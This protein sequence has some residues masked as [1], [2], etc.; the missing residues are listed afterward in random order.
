MKPILRR[1]LLACLASLFLLAGFSAWLLGTQSG[2]QH[3]LGWLQTWSGGKLQFA[4]ANGRWLGPLRLDEIVWQEADAAYRARDL[5]LDWQPAALFTLGRRAVRIDALTVGEIRLET[6]PGNDSPAALPQTLALPVAFSVAQLQVGHLQIDALP[7]VNDVAAVLRSDGD[8]HRLEKLGFNVAGVRVQAAGELGGEAPFAL[9]AQARIDGQIE[10]RP[11]ALAIDAAGSLEQLALELKPESGMRGRAAL[12]LTPFAALPFADAELDL[13]AID[14]ADWAEGLPQAQLALRASFRPEGGAETPGVSGDFVLTNRLPGALDQNRLPFTH[15][16]G[17]LRWRDGKLAF[18]ALQL[19]LP[20]SG[21]ISGEGRW[22]GELNPAGDARLELQLAVRKL[23]ART[24]LTSLEKTRLDG[25]VRALLGAEKQTLTADLRDARFTLAANLAHAG[26]EVD[27][28][29]LLLQANGAGL[30]A[31]GRLRLDGARD[32]SI[33]AEL[34]DFNPRAFADL[35]AARINAQAKASG[36]LGDAPPVG[37]SVDAEFTLHD[38]HYRQAALAGSGNVRLAWPRVSAADLWLSLGE[39]RLAARGAFGRSGDRL[40]LT[41][42]APRL[43]D[44][45]AEGSAHGQFELAGSLE[46]LRLRGGLQSPRLGW[47]GLFLA[48]ELQLQAD[49]SEGAGGKVGSAP[50]AIDFSLAR[51]DLPTQPSLAEKLALRISGSRQQHDLNFVGQ[52]AGGERLEIGANGSLTSQPTFA[53]QGAL[54]QLQLTS[55]NSSRNARLQAPA[56]LRISRDA[57]QLADLHLAGAPLDWQARLSAQVR[58]ARLNLTLKAD[59]TRFGT[60]AARLAASMDGAWALAQQQPWQGEVELEAADLGWLGEFIGE[61]RQTGG[62]LRGQL[63]LAGSPGAPQLRGDLSGRDLRLALADNGLQLQDGELR[64]SV[65]NEVLHVETLHF[66]SVPRALPR[67]LKRSLG[68]AAARHEMPGKL[69]ASGELRLDKQAAGGVAQIAV[70]LDRVGVWQLPEQWVS[71]SGESQLSWQQDHLG[72]SGALTIDAGYW[73]L[74]PAGAPSLSDDVVVRR[75]A[76]AAPQTLRPRLDLDLGVDFGRNF[77]FEGAGLSSRLAG[78]IRLTAQGR[79]LPRAQGSIRTRDGR[80]AAYGQALEIERGILNFQGLPDNPALDVRAMRRG[81][82]VEAGVEVSG[83]AQKPRIR[84]VSEP[85]LPDAEKLTWLILGHGPENV[86]SGDASVLFAAAGDLLGNG[87]GNLVGQLKDTFGI[88]E[89]GV[90]QGKL[91]GGARSAGSRIVSSGSTESGSVDQQILSVGKR[92]SSRATLT[93][94]QSLG[95]AESIAKLS[96]ALTRQITLVGRVG[97]DNAVDVFYGLSWGRPPREG[98]NK[99]GAPS[100]APT[101]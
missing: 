93:Y 67:A 59:G 66:T 41:L 26:G 100:D 77:L 46:A 81:L 70:K 23:D 14:L 89:F 50:L 96:F 72:A 73:Q 24:L 40:Q 32:F 13:S 2:L 53:W 25:Q 16:S 47:P 18:P 11:L 61:G 71:L 83:T 49:V 9:Q 62:S 63:R 98:R 20:E 64:A 15:F 45:G 37:A 68:E 1:F 92:L 48:R 8:T 76:Q 17:A 85:E 36:S 33:Q 75:P 29:R 94:E 58:A 10:G 82:A 6:G 60:L 43:S 3:S 30:N 65:R 87:S 22:L 69:S 21:E 80:F 56:S 4:A 55:R 84:L 95:T 86:G 88:D 91:G 90:H 101:P 27:V 79:D 7:P 99:A 51:L 54:T 38:S 97:S 19:R 57:W 52:I 78:N 44:L 31:S 28:S 34:K 74:A 42:D 39:N 12:T 5:Q 35:P